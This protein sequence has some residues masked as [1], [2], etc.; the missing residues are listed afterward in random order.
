MNLDIIDENHQPIGKANE[1]LGVRIKREWLT[2]TILGAP[3][4]IGQLAQIS[5][6]VVD[7]IMAGHASADDLTGVAIGNSLWLPLMLFMIGLLNATQPIISGYRGANQ[8]HKT[9][10]VTWNAVY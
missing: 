1:P 10:P 8:P 5:N 3:I 2:L 9:M 4:L 6:G 7:T